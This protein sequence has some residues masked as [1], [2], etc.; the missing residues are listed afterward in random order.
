YVLDGGFA[1][2]KQAGND[3]TKEI[4][5]TEPTS[6]K[7]SLLDRATADMSEV[8]ARKDESSVFLI[9]SRSKDRYLGKEENK[10]QQAGH[11]PGAKNF[12]WK[13]VLNEDGTWKSKDALKEQFSSIPKDDEIIVSCGS[14]ISACPN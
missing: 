12:F 3:V 10:Y 5:K 1:A 9:D 4:V 8:K 7:L 6:F 13:E 2:W 11:I 14:G